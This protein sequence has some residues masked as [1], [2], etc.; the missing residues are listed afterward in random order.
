MVSLF[1]VTRA[2]PETPSLTR[3]GEAGRLPVD[4]CAETVCR[5]ADLTTWSFNGSGQAG[6]GR[7]ANVTTSR[8]LRRTA[9]AVIGLMGLAAV[10]GCGGAVPAPTAFSTYQDVGGK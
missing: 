1:S 8:I 10:G 3:L 6:Q 2:R 4:T 9:T 5:F 7:G